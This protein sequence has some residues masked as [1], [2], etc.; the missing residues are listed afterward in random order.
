MLCVFFHTTSFPY[1]IPILFIF[2]DSHQMQAFLW[3]VPTVSRVRDQLVSLPKQ[4]YSHVAT[5]PLTPTAI[6]IPP[7]VQCLVTQSHLTL[8]NPMA[9]SP[10]DSSV[11]GDSPGK[12]TGV[13]CHVL[14]QGSSQPRDQTQASCIAG[15]FFTS[16]ATREAQEY[17]SG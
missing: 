7:P 14:L 8:W 3:T 4:N 1:H 6:F 9:Y 11:H 16:W 10:P 17:W 13:S 5:K 2:Q 12:N 15:G